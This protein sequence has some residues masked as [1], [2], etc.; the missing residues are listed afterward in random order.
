MQKMDV[1]IAWVDGSEPAWKR[2]R[3]HYLGE[4]ETPAAAD[5]TRFASNDEIYFCIASILKYVPFCGTIFLVT[6]Q[7]KPKFLDEFFEQ[8]LCEKN[9][10]KIIDHAEIFSGYENFLPTFNSLTIESMLWKIPGLS[11]FFLYLNDDFFFNAPAKIEDFVDAEKIIV[12]GR[13]KSALPLKLKMLARQ[14]VGKVFSKKIAARHTVSQMLSADLAGFGEFFSVH[15]YPH[16][17]DKDAMG[18]FFQANPDVLIHQITHRFRSIEQFNPVALALHLKI[19]K[20]EAV[21]HADVSLAYLKNN[22]SVDDFLEK[23]KMKNVLYGCIQSWDQ[24]SEPLA[25]TIHSAM[26]EKF[27]DFLPNSIGKNKNEN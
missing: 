19:K 4:S 15:H 2:K 9:K 21:L 25:N 3:A 16:V 14:C 23:I 18:E 22:K 10:I 26:C 12:G 1:V 8:G 5:A 24:L 7:Q 13:W 20:N 6:D 27:K 11:R 17:L